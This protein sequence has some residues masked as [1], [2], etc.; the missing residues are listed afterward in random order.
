MDV[1]L[2]LILGIGV[3]IYGSMV[4]WAMWDTFVTHNDDID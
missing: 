2:G 1:I 3:L 4:L